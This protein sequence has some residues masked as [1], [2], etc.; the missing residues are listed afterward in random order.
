VFSWQSLARSDL[1]AESKNP[2]SLFN[3]FQGCLSLRIFVDEGGT[4]IPAT[5]WGVVCSLALPHKEVGPARREI[6]RASRNWSRHKG[7]LKGG[8][9]DLA[10]LNVLVDILFRHDALLHACATDVSREDP[11]AVDR[12]KMVQCENSRNILRRSIMLNW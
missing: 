4:F 9:L 11:S 3:F 8:A 2:N 5:G 10:E 6:I 12:H 7:E 1:I